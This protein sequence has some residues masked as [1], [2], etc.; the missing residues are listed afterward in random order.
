MHHH[1]L[2]K[3]KLTKIPTLLVILLKFFQVG[4]LEMIHNVMVVV[5]KTWI[6][7]SF[8]E[9]SDSPSYICKIIAI[10]NEKKVKVA[11]VRWFARGENTIFGLVLNSCQ[12]NSCILRNNEFY[13]FVLKFLINFPLK[14][15]RPL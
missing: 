8:P 13:I 12:A 15:R 5:I 11:H 1:I 10:I 9:D 7:F 6:F 3:C 4:L 14:A 2:Q